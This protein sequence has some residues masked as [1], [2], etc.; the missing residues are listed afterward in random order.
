MCVWGGGHAWVIETCV[1]VGVGGGACMGDRDL[2]KCRCVCGGGACMGDRDL[3]KC[4]CV[5]GG[6]HAWVI[7]TCVSVGVGGG[8]HG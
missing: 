2:C 6:G 8:M 3:C 4:R 7:E 5:G 1:S